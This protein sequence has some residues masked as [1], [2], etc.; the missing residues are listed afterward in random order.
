MEDFFCL[1]NKIKKQTE[2]K[3]KQIEEW[4]ES[5]YGSLRN[6]GSE[7][8]SCCAVIVDFI[9]RYRI[10]WFYIDHFEFHIR[11]TN[12]WPDFWSDWISLCLLA[13]LCFACK[14]HNHWKHT[15][16]VFYWN[17][18]RNSQ[19]SNEMGIL[20][21]QT[22]KN[23]LAYLWMIVSFVFFFC[24]AC[25]LDWMQ[26]FCLQ[27]LFIRVM[28]KCHHT[29][30]TML[31]TSRRTCHLQ[32]VMYTKYNDGIITLAIHSD[33]SWLNTVPIHMLCLVLCHC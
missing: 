4:N 2:G 5:T 26:K 11:R 3:K 17:F 13:L 27:L 28:C 14:S 7:R 8:W 23:A 18:L 19:H 24:W 29:Q 30:L 10:F 22:T 25:G 1:L 15:L 9:T 33:F 20:T 12:V 31:F 16:R 21:R 6:A 32:I